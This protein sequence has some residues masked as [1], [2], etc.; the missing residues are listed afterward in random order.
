MNL[1]NHNNFVTR[2][3]L[4]LRLALLHV[5]FGN[6]LVHVRTTTRH[7]CSIRNYTRVA[8]E[9]LAEGESLGWR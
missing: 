2:Q 8:F 7:A 6:V 3:L 1:A 4:R 5:H 9:L